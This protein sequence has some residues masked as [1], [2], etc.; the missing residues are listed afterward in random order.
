MRC[1]A[2]IVAVLSLGQTACGGGKGTK[3]ATHT[4]TPDVTNPAEPKPEA[5]AGAVASAA[6]VL[7]TAECESLLVHMFG[8]IYQHKTESLPENEQPSPEDMKMAKDNLRVELMKRCE[9]AAPELFAFDCVM[10]SKSFEE[11]ASCQEAVPAP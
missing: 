6:R 9:G 2:V 5:D 10:A 11:M 7:T 1:L 4:P 3:K 8:H